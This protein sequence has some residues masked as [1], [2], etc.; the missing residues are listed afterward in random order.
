M[1]VIKQNQFFT[2]LRIQKGLTMIEGMAREL[3]Y[4]VEGEDYAVLIDGLTGIGSLRAFV[5]ELT[6]LPVVMAATHGHMDHIGAAWEYGE[7][8]IHPN[9][10]ALMYTELGGGVQRRFEFVELYR[11]MGLQTRTIPTMADVV[12]SCAIKTYPVYNGDVFAL[13]GTKL[14]VIGVPGHTCGSVVFL[15]RARRIAFCGDACNANTL[16]NLEG[17]T[18]I[19][20][21]RESLLHFKS[22]QAAVDQL[23]CG[24]D[25]EPYANTIID[26]GIVLCD[27][28]LSG[29]DDAIPVGDAFGG[30]SR[31]AARRDDSYTP[32]CGGRCNIVYKMEAVHRAA[33]PAIR[34]TPNLYHPVNQEEGN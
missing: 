3:C 10:I 2:A 15:D 33:Q 26:D 25:R 32:S 13:G 8:F 31:L 7:V 34:R 18:S 9:D 27:R 5:R 30:A 29:T 23:Y 4:L 21:Y 16:L 19:E 20:E 17:S 1:E 28:I 6:E 22:V 12:K 24:H 11:K 14:E